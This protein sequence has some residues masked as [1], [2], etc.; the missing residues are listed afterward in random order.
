MKQVHTRPRAKRGGTGV[1]FTKS[2]NLQMTKPGGCLPVADGDH[3]LQ[4]ERAEERSRAIEPTSRPPFRR[5]NTPVAP[6]TP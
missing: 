2:G 5:K 3:A 4:Q 1:R 6:R